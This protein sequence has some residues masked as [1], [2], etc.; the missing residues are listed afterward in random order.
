MS[1]TIQPRFGCAWNEYVQRM[2]VPST[3]ASKSHSAS[4]KATR[5]PNVPVKSESR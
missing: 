1:R 4:A 5:P 3:E 2:R